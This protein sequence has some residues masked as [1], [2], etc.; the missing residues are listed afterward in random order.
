VISLAS[1]RFWKTYQALPAGV[2]ELADK[3]F[4]LWRANPRHPSLRF[5]PIGGDLWSAR[6]GLHYRAV[7]RFHDDDT[8]V[9][10]WIGSHEEYDRL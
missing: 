5:R 7:G 8:F 3:N 10:L 1:P 2:R 6:V 9:W 4:A